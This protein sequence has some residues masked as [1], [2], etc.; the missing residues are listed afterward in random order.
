MVR[1]SH[2]FVGEVKWI[3][4]RNK[5]K[6]LTK[7]KHMKKLKN[8]FLMTLAAVSLVAC[9]S[10]GDQGAQG[11]QGQPGTNAA[12]PT[13]D[14]LS[15]SNISTI[16]AGT[17]GVVDLLLTNT[18]GGAAGNHLNVV[19]DTLALQLTAAGNLVSISGLGHSSRIP[20]AA[21]GAIAG[22]VAE[23]NKPYPGA[24]V[25]GFSLSF[26]TAA[27]PT[28]LNAGSPANAP[29]DAV[30]GIFVNLVPKP[31]SLNE[32]TFT[33]VSRETNLVGDAYNS[34]GTFL[35]RAHAPTIVI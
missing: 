35:L 33:L 2:F 10:K 5:Y 14:V 20:G 30:L 19:G 15:F 32:G 21:L 7:N 22:F 3:K 12:L 31:G 25:N 29:F 23:A 11:P 6:Q 34:T 16:G 24:L 28:A 1:L 17:A 8:L 18:A 9:G 4:V 26:V 13:N 27:S